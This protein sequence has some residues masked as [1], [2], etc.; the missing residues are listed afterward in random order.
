[1]QGVFI[2]YFGEK[3]HRVPA[4]EGRQDCVVNHVTTAAPSWQAALS[5]D[6]YS[7]CGCAGDVDGHGLRQLPRAVVDVTP[8]M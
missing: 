6:W 3:F 8:R 4:L 7:C 2:H 1:M 5:A